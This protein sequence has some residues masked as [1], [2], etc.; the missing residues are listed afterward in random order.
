M[1]ARDGRPASMQRDANKSENREQLCL[2]TF[3]VDTL[4]PGFAIVRDRNSSGRSCMEYPTGKRDLE[5]ISK[6]FP[7]RAA[8]RAGTSGKGAALA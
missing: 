3:R 2:P 6:W 4:S 8:A 1:Q 5:Q 7:Q